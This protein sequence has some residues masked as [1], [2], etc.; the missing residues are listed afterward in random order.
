MIRTVPGALSQARELVAPVLKTCLEGLAPQI[1]RVVEYHLGFT[2][3]EGRPASGNGGKAVRP[4]LALLSAEAVGAPAEVAFPGAVAVE[5]VHNFSLLHDD[6]MDRDT[7][8][9]HRPTAW[10]LFGVG[11]AIVAGEALQELAH[12]VLMRPPTQERVRAADALAGAVSLMIAGQAEDL[13]FE[14]RLDVSVEECLEMSAHKTGA[15]LSCA[16]SIGAILAGGPEDAVAALAGFGLHLGLAFQ[17]VDDVLG[18]WGRP[19]VTGKPAWSDLRQHKKSLPV[20]AALRS[21]DP[22]RDRLAALLSNGHLEEAEV[23]GAAGLV[24]ACG[25]RT[26]A[27]EEAE[28]QLALAV[29]ALDRAPILAEARAQLTEIAAFVTAREF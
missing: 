8:R 26:L 15:L 17:A 11:Q 1:R 20:V 21:P 5:L 22:R 2:D 19:E 25:G 23:A 24:E 12:Q 18:I 14:S 10:A 29:S 7:E 13:E 28:R 9:R 16:S 4:A 6:V 27:V 3:P